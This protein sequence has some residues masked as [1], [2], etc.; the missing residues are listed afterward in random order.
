MALKISTFITALTVWLILA[1]GVA[2]AGAMYMEHRGDLARGY[3]F[4]R[5]A[6]DLGD[7]DHDGTDEMVIADDE[8]GFHVYHYTDSGF[9]PVWISDPIVENGYIVDVKILHDGIPGV[10]AQILLLDSDGTLHTVQYNGY[11][12]EE[13]EVFENYR[14]PGESGRLV[15]TDLLSEGCMGCKTVIIALPMTEVT[16]SE[17][18]ETEVDTSGVEEESAVMEPVGNVDEW[19]GM[20]LYKMSTN[21]FVELSETEIASLD[22]GEIYLVQEFT[23]EDLNEL[24]TLVASNEVNGPYESGRAG[25]AD[26]NRDTL[27]DLLVSVSDPS[28]PVDH[29]EVYTEEDGGFVVSVTVELPLL[30]EMVLGDV[31]GDEFTEI[32]GLTFDGE[33]LVYQYDPLTVYYGDDFTVGFSSPHEVHEEKIWVAADGFSDLGCN[34]VITDTFTEVRY[35]DLVVTLDTVAGEIRCGDDV[36]ASEI[37][38]HLYETKAFLP[39]LAILEC[40]GFS[41]SIDNLGYIVNVETMQ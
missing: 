30:N 37:P 27:L 4:F 3:S 19:T 2:N 29:L 41:Y 7:I 11:L 9:V 31:D 24:M 15:L 33:V 8:G 39:L 10:R 18:E 32:V 17:S 12:Y 5:G 6:F 28:R 1:A 16:A 13:T 14:V 40:L 25:L 38:A 34:L 35:Q 22:D 23:G 20:T 36:I 21:G 26:L